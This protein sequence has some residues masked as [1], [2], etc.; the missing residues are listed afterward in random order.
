MDVVLR[1]VLKGCIRY[2][3]LLD[4]TVGLYDIALLNDALDVTLENQML[5]EQAMRKEKK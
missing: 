3:S 5:A 4:G 1:P 2:E